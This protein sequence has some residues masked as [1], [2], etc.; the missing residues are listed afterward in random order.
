MRR[1]LASGCL[2]LFACV[3]EPA[4]RE[5][6]AETAGGEEVCTGVVSD[7]VVR[8]VLGPIAAELGE[9]ANGRCPARQLL[10]HSMRVR[11]DGRVDH[12]SFGGCAMEV[13]IHRDCA[14]H[15][16]LSRIR[17]PPLE[18]G[19]CAWIDVPASSDRRPLPE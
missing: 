15:E 11:A 17:F 18:S 3:G 4:P 16:V 7:E 8:E 9:R 12:A 14:A 6:D 13:R 10:G 2:I 5:A 19:E 1:A